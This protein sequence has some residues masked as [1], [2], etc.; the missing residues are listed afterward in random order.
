MTIL[1][2]PLIFLDR[3]QFFDIQANQNPPPAVKN[4]DT[5][6]STKLTIYSVNTPT[7]ASMKTVYI[8][9]IHDE[10]VRMRKESPSRM[11]ARSPLS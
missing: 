6:K 3:I 10:V 5:P 11:L 2:V 1:W 9:E 7:R 4:L 8:I